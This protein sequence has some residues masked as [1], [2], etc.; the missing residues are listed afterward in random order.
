MLLLLLLLLLLLCEEEG[1]DEEEVHDQRRIVAAGAD[2]DGA[3]VGVGLVVEACDGA[4]H[5]LVGLVVGEGEAEIG[6]AHV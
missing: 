5:Q 2:R 4:V 6:R 3:D 1:S